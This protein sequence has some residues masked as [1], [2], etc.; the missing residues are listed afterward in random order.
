MKGKIEKGDCYIKCS[1]CSN[2]ILEGNSEKVANILSLREKCIR[3]VSIEYTTYMDISEYRVDTPVIFQ[4]FK[5]YICSDILYPIGDE[6][7]IFPGIN[8]SSIKLMVCDEDLNNEDYEYL[9]II[10]NNSNDETN[11]VKLLYGYLLLIVEF[12]TMEKRSVYE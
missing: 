1:E 7:L 2:L 3:K 10:R 9:M 6:Y 11:V 8:F 5:R 12:Y 4:F